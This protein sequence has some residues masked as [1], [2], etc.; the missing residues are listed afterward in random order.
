MPGTITEL[1]LDL[2]TDEAE[3]KAAQDLAEIE[4]R[5]A[6]EAKLEL[7]RAQASAEHE[8]NEARQALARAEEAASEAEAARGLRACAEAA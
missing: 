3:L 8:A 5:E 6:E 1:G 2:A 7:E 4:K